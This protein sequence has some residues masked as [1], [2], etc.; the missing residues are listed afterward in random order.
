[1]SY[2]EFVSLIGFPFAALNLPFSVDTI[3][4]FCES[5]FMTQVLSAFGLKYWL[6]VSIS[7]S[8]QARFPAAISLR[9]WFCVDIFLFTIP[10]QFG[11]IRPL[12]FSPCLKKAWH[13]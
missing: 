5:S 4:S 12:R 1:M 3:F 10:W 8:I 2:F 13:V 7:S 11:V 9:S 6:L